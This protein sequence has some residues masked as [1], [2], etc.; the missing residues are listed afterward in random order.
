MKKLILAMPYNKNKKM[1]FDLD[2][3]TTA[4]CLE[5]CE[6][7]INGNMHI[8]GPHNISMY[9]DEGV[10]YLQI[11]KTRWPMNEK[12]ISLSYSHDFALQITQFV[13]DDYVEKVVISYPAWW[14]GLGSKVQCLPEMDE[15]QD[16]LA[17]VCAVWRN[18][19]LR[20]HLLGAWQKCN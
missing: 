1:E 8:A 12:A 17:Y 19:E 9:A 10:L 11:D 15:D 16:Y 5:N 4:A 6:D 18:P 13:V 20:T 14:K 7:K 3:G 2:S